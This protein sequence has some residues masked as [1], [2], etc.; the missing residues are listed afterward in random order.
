MVRRPRGRAC[1]AAGSGACDYRLQRSPRL[2]ALEP[3]TPPRAVQKASACGASRDGGRRPERPGERGEA[4]ATRDQA[5]SYLRTR[6]G[7]WEGGDEGVKTCALGRVLGGLGRG[8]PTASICRSAG[9]GRRRLWDNGHL[10]GCKCRST[11][12]R[13]CFFFCS[14]LCRRLCG[15]GKIVTRTASAPRTI[16]IVSLPWA[17]RTIPPHRDRRSSSVRPGVQ[18]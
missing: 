16:R 8:R 13:P 4:R 5:R 3:E 12:R 6:P 18:Q 15:N 7:F 1:V 2:P 14:C 10:W 11:P 9:R 17:P